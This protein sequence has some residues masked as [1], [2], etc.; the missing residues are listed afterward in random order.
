MLKIPDSLQTDAN[1]ITQKL[2]TAL[3]AD[4]VS[5][6]AYGRWLLNDPPDIS[7]DLNLMI[8]LRQISTEL[9]DQLAQARAQSQRDWQFLTLSEADL[10]SSTDVFPIKFIGIQR[11]YC[12][13]HGADVLRDLKISREHLRFRCEQEIKNLMLRLRYHYI[14]RHGQKDAMRTMLKRASHS[15]M[16][17]LA[18]LIELKT[19]AVPDGRSAIFSGADE[20][21]I[22]MEPLRRILAGGAAETYDKSL[23]GELMATV[24]QAAAKADQA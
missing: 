2:K 5:M 9:L 19:G 12:L 13:L 16:S 1:A 15:L 23:F 7:A 18:I 4:L 3:G 24:R 20:L 10:A 8:V 11:R 17:S 14:N 6:I 21:G 22:A